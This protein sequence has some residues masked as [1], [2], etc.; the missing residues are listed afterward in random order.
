MHHYRYSFKP[1]IHV[2]GLI[3]SIRTIPHNPCIEQAMETAI[4]KE[5]LVEMSGFLNFFASRSFA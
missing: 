2:H 1:F 3:F 5:S 4:A